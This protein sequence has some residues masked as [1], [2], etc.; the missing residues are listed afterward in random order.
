MALEPRTVTAAEVPSSELIAM[1]QRLFVCVGPAL[2]VFLMG[3]SDLIPAMPLHR[4]VSPRGAL[5]VE[6]VL[7][8]PVVVWGGW[9]FFVRA[10]HSLVHRSLNMFTL[11]GLGIGSAYRYSVVAFL[12]P[13]IFPLS[14]SSSRPN[15]RAGFAT[16][17]SKKTF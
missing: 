3:M 7:A 6:F 12:A 4:L 1:K 13:G 2:A 5:G 15:R 16:P 9:P 14:S 11:L 8:T 10:W 17:E